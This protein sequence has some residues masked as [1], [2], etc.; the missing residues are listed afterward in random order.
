MTA[1]DYRLGRIT[2]GMAAETVPVTRTTGGQDRRT[3]AQY[4]ADLQRETD[5]SLRRSAN[6]RASRALDDH[7]DACDCPPLAG[8]VERRPSLASGDL[9]SRADMPQT[10]R[11]LSKAE[12]QRQRRSRQRRS[13]SQP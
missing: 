11:Q 10:S 4:A 12:Q 9:G 6:W 7:R 1:R 5:R 2:P 3:D 8:C 13:G